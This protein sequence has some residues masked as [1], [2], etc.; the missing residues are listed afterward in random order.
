MIIIT[1]F[2]LNYN[3]KNDVYSVVPDEADETRSEARCPLCGG[4]VTYRDSKR[5]DS[6]NLAGEIRHF[7]LRRLFCAKCEKLHTEIPSIIQPYKHYDSKTIQSVLDGSAEAGACVADDS[8][9]R[10]WKAD[11]AETEPD[12][13][14]RLASIYARAA[15]GTAPILSPGMPLVD[16]RAN[17]ERWLA[18]VMALLINSGHK[19]RARF[20]FCPSQFL[21]KVGTTDKTI[22]IGGKRNDKTI[23]D[24]G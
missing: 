16:V 10:R 22:G 23:E 24:S 3:Y 11:F 2:K 9:I 17:I 7:S 14:L 19:I 13:T 4:L 18:F 21:V 15:Y 1:S 12:I 20:A 6:K 5:R 8:T